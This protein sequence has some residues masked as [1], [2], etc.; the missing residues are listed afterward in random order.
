MALVQRA[1]APPNVQLPPEYLN[2]CMHKDEKFKDFYWRVRTLEKKLGFQPDTADHQATIELW[3]SRLTANLFH[4]LRVDSKETLKFETVYHL[5]ERCCS[6]E[7]QD[8]VNETRQM[9][10]SRF[11]FNKAKNWALFEAE[12]DKREKLLGYFDIDEPEELSERRRI[13]SWLVRLL[14]AEL[15]SLR[16]Y[17]NGLESIKTEQELLECLRQVEFGQKWEALVLNPRLSRYWWEIKLNDMAPEQEAATQS[18]D[19]K[20]T[21]QKSLVAEGHEEQEQEATVPAVKEK[22]RKKKKSRRAQEEDVEEEQKSSPRAVEGVRFMGF[23]SNQMPPF[24]KD[25]SRRNKKSRHAQEEDEEE[26]PES[27]PPAVEEKT[28]KRKKSHKIKQEVEEEVALPPAVEAKPRKL[29]KRVHFEDDD[30]EVEDPL[31]TFKDKPRRKKSRKAEVDEE[32]A[33]SPTVVKKKSRK[34]DKSRKAKED[35]DDDDEEEQEYVPTPVVKEKRRKSKKKSR[36]VED[37][38]EQLASPPAIKHKSRK[39]KRRHVEVDSDEAEADSSD[40]DEQPRKR[41][42]IRSERREKRRG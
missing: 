26:E 2:I 20:G 10:S 6:I 18:V 19:N 22:S 37:E 38:D 21:R 1:S 30:D 8:R 13:D 12:V 11:H 4:K 29:K 27:P 23:Y 36:Q 5:F 32:E 31:P 34:G 33:V 25:K 15:E 17:A 7:C 14:P 35:D 40:V 28:R 41:K 16:L 24:F 42:K 39:R 3:L 9:M